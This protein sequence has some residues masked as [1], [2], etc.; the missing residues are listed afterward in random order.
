MNKIGLKIN[1]FFFKTSCK[2][3]Q[4]KIYNKTR[5]ETLLKLLLD[6]VVKDLHFNLSEFEMFFY[7]IFSES[8]EQNNLTITLRDIDQI[9]SIVSI[10]FFNLCIAKDESNVFPCP[11]KRFN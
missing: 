4:R 11:K 3:R 6:F 9:V 2:E 1:D 7:K 10:Y 8:L 5:L